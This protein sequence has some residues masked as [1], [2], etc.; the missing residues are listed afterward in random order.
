VSIGNLKVIDS[1]TILL[2]SEIL[3]A[4]ERKPLDGSR[5]KAGIKNFHFVRGV[6]ANSVKQKA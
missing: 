2:F 3:L 1:N 5:R 4:V 6:K